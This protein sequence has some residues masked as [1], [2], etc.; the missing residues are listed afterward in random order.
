MKKKTVYLFYYFII[1]IY[2]NM[3]YKVYKLIKAYKP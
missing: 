1:Y 3:K 2:E